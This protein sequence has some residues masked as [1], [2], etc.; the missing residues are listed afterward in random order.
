MIADMDKG[1]M[2][3][4]FAVAR[5]SAVLAQLIHVKENLQ[6]FMLETA[7]TVIL[8]ISGNMAILKLN[9]IAE[10]I[11]K[12]IAADSIAV[13]RRSLPKWKVLNGAFCFGIWASCLGCILIS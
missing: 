10:K 13:S 5:I 11:A 8:H 9:T 1:H 7:A 3:S 2:L 6:I 4:Y 12:Q